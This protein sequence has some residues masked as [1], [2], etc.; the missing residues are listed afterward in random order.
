MFN[1]VH[2]EFDHLIINWIKIDILV[3]AGWVHDWKVC[4]YVSV[5]FN[6]NAR[7]DKKNILHN[8]RYDV[9]AIVLQSSKPVLTI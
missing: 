2:L 8:S 6:L 1:V 4:M 5:N 9:L 3:F 7:Y